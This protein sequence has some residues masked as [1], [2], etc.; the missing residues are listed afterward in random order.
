MINSKIWIDKIIDCTYRL[1]IWSR[2]VF[3]ISRHKDMTEGAAVRRVI[4]RVAVEGLGQTALAQPVPQERRRHNRIA[5]LGRARV[6]GAELL[7]R[8]RALIL[9]FEMLPDQ[10]GAEAVARLPSR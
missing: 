2:A 9:F 10:V 4:G 6:L 1:S 5:D 8:P 7:A 3:D